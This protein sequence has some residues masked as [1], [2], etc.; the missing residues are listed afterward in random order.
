M[1]FL[2]ASLEISCIFIQLISNDIC[3]STRGVHQEK[4]L[5]NHITAKAVFCSVLTSDCIAA[6]TFHNLAPLDSLK[7][8]RI[9]QNP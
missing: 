1:R 4:L 8:I 3:H 2:A 9:L 5:F 6:A 7:R